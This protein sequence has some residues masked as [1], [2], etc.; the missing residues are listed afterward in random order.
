MPDKQASP[1][2]ELFDHFAEMQRMRE[3]FRHPGEPVEIRSHDTAWVPSTDIFAHGD[4]LVIRCE[5]A[6]VEPEDVEISLSR[7]VLWI[8]GERRPRPDQ[9]GDV[10]YYTRERRFGP[11]RR[12]LTLPENVG[13]DRLRASMENGLLEIVIVGGAATEHHDRIEVGRRGQ[14]TDV[15]VDVAPKAAER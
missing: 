11:F 1:F 15:A 3:H 5:L 7:G 10:S 2:R 8:G 4:D 14:R 9:A 6:G 13:K 12:S